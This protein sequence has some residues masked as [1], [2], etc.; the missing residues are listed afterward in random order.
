MVTSKRRKAGCVLGNTF[1][2]VVSSNILKPIKHLGE[3]IYDNKYS[4]EV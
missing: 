2:L 1:I 4:V 3:I